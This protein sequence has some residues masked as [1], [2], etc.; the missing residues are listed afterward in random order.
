MTATSQVVLAVEGQ[1]G[2]LIIDRPAQRNAMTQ[3]MWQAVADHLTTIRRARLR[4][5]ILSSA[6]EHFCSG[7]DI[8][9]LSAQCLNPVELRANALLVQEVQAEL[10]ALE[11]PTLAMIRGVCVGGGVGLVAACDMRFATPDAR[12]AL[13]PTRL[14]LHYSL[15]DTRRVA[16]LIGLARTREMLLTADL[17]DAAQAL[18][19][20][21]LNRVVDDAHS[22]EKQAM[23]QAQAWVDASP[24][25]L[26]CTKRVLRQLVTGAVD[27]EMDLQAAFMNAFDGLDFREGIS[28][29]LEKRVAQFS[30]HAMPSERLE[31]P[32]S[33]SNE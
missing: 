9:E 28:A 2:R 5:L 8:S 15:A 31:S 19:W 7:A 26:A 33:K 6:G 13:T 10:A 30:D 14:G 17:V 21:L 24:A 4:A 12:F 20:G 18:S 25:A 23:Q 32:P 16:S 1:V 11:I 22:L 27:D 29:F 3:A